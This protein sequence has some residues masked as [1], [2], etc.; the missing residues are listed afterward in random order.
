MVSALTVAAQMEKSQSFWDS[1][2]NLKKK[3]REILVI[4]KDPQLCREMSEKFPEARIL[5]GDITDDGLL[6]NE[7]VCECDLMVAASGNYERNLLT[8]AYLKLR[9]VSKVIALTSDSAFDEIA[10]KLGVNVTVPMRDVVIDSIMSHL[11][12]RNIKS[13]HSVGSRK[14]EIVSCEVSPESKAAGKRGMLVVVSEGAFTEDGRPT[15]IMDAF[16][17]WSE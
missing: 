7:G 10:S 5:N 2:F 1:I 14:Y 12:G 4:D 3:K 8:A 11:R 17:D 13:V 6:Q 15:V 16:S 9:G